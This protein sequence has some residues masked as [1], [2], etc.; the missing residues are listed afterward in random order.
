MVTL[1]TLIDAING[2]KHKVLLFAQA[3]LPPQQFE[4]FRKLFLN[5]FGRNGLEQDLARIV[6]EHQ[7]ERNR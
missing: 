2:R 4:A 6:V 5:E 7:S 3:A 1:Q